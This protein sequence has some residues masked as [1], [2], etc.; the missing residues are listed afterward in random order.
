MFNF[1][2]NCA[3]AKP[4]FLNGTKIVCRECGF[5]IYHNTAA[6]V[7]LLI[8]M[9]DKYILLKRGREP[10]LGLLDLPGGF[11]DPDES[12]EE[13]CRREVRE[14][15]GR[16]IS[17]LRYLGSHPNTYPYKG[18]TYKTCDLL[19]TARCAPGDFFR[20]ENEIAGIILVDKKSVPIEKIAFLS[21]RNMLK[22][23]LPQLDNP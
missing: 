19:F 10:G 1:C 13:A 20:Q 22:E 16:E 6:A 2:P 3:A 11:V 23:H 5:Q 14:E 18:I 9:D 21:L 17:G 12:A 8:E 7:A 4:E 15:I